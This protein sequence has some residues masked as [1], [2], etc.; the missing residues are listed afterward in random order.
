[1][2]CLFSA[3]GDSVS[4]NALRTT[5]ARL[6]D[7]C[8]NRHD[9]ST[10]TPTDGA[11]RLTP[12]RHRQTHRDYGCYV[13]GAPMPQMYIGLK[14]WTYCIRFA[15]PH[16]ALKE[17]ADLSSWQVFRDAACQA[18]SLS[19]FGCRGTWRGVV[20]RQFGPKRSGMLSSKQRP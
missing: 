18:A 10:T 1:M 14:Y 15:F 6:I 7:V 3:R 19:T 11:T 2:L 9:E 4:L 12:S 8:D 13:Q 17:T 16:Q 20:C 5:T